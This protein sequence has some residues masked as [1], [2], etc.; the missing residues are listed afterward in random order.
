MSGLD[1]QQKAILDFWFA[2]GLDTQRA[3]WFRRDEAFDEAIRKSFW[4][5]PDQARDGAFDHWLGTPEGSLALLLV[6]DQFPRNL[7]RG[8]E[9][10]FAYDPKARE[11]ARE[12]VLTH[13]HDEALPPAARVF[14]Y[15]P[16][17][18]SEALADQDL[19]VSL[20]ERLRDYPEHRAE[21]GS[22]DY[23]L[24]HRDVIRRFGRFPHRNAILGRASTAEEEAYLREP[25]A[26]F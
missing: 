6:L 8:Q 2:D 20:F 23:A 9:R 26:G 17:E 25:G 12:A 22:I 24:R 19:S 16:F 21:G 1:R 18:H 15:L 13:R 3:A 5:L 11:A 7:F 4:T 14:L 10:A